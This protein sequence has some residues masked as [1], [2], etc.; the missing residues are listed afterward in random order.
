MGTKWAQSGHKVGTKWAQIVGTKCAVIYLSQFAYGPSQAR[1]VR[2]MMQSTL[3]DTYAAKVLVVEAYMLRYEL[4][5]T[6]KS[7][8]LIKYKGMTQV[9]I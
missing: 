7:I 6:Q 3:L 5:T 2:Y 8:R 9:L 1:L 4:N